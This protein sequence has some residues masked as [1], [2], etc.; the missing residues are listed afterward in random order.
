MIEDTV[1]ELAEVGCIAVDENEMDLKINN[2]GM[3]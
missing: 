3:I 2:L 1:A